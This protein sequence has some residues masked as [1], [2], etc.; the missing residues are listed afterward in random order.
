MDDNPE[1]KNQ[2]YH[3]VLRYSNPCS[4]LLLTISYHYFSSSFRVQR[5]VPVL[6]AEPPPPYTPPVGQQQQQQQPLRS[7]S[8]IINAR[9]PTR[10]LAGTKYHYSLVDGTF[11]VLS[12]LIARTFFPTICS[13]AS[14]QPLLSLRRKTEMRGEKR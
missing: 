5:P 14:V 1:C 2:D 12:V 4:K 13:L 6:P 9:K 10:P 3:Q 7:V 8:L 11:A